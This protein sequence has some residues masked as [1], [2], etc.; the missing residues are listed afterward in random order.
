[1]KKQ[2][3]R[4]IFTF[5][6]LSMSAST[7]MGQKGVFFS[8]YAEGTSSNKYLEVYNGSGV[9]IN[10]NHYAIRSAS[11]GGG[12]S[13]S[14]TRFNG[15]D[16]ILKAGAVYVIGNA[17]A[18][19]TIK[20]SSDETNSV[21]F[22]NGNDARA[23]VYLSGS[24]TLI[25]DQVCD[26]NNSGYDDVAGI[27]EGFRNDGAWIRKAH[28]E[29]GNYG[30]WN[31]SRGT[32]SASSEWIYTPGPTA[33][34]TPSTLKLH[35]Q[36]P[37]RYFNS[38]DMAI[39]AYRASAS[40]IAD[41]FALLTFV[42]IKEG[43][44]IKI[45]D[46]K[47]TENGIAQCEGGLI[48]TAPAGIKSGDVIIVGNDNAVVDTGKIEGSSFG[49]SSGGD[50]IIIYEGPFF[51]PN[52]I[53]ALS[54]NAWSANGI[55]SCKGSNSMLPKGL[56]NGT[57]AIS[58]ENTQGGS[59]GNATNGFYSGS[60]TGTVAEVKA[61]VFDYT[62]WNGT[63]TKVDQIWPA[64]N[65]FKEVQA[66]S[67]FALINP[68]NGA[69]ITVLENDTTSV[70]I[71]WHSAKD[72]LGYAWKITT[73]TGDFNTPAIVLPSD[74]SGKDT[75]LTLT[76]GAV[77]AALA[78]LSI[79]KGVKVDLKW[80]VTAYFITGDSM[81]ADT[82]HTIAITRKD[83][84]PI[85][86]NFNAGDMAVIAYRMNASTPDEFALLTFVD[87]PAGAQLNFSD[88]KFAAGVQCDGGDL[89]WTAPAGGV[90][91]GTVIAVLNDNPAVSL[92]TVTGGSFGLSSGGD[93]IM[94]FE[95]PADKAKHIT[96]LSSNKWETSGIS[97]TSKSSSELPTGLTN[98]VNAISHEMTAGNDAGNTVNAFYT[99][100][101]EGTFDEIKKL[102]ADYTNWNGAA[103]GTEAQQW[104]SWNFTGKAASTSKYSNTAYSV[105]PNP[106][107]GMVFFSK[108]IKATVYTISGVEIFRMTEKMSRFD[109]SELGAGV[110]IIQSEFGNTHKVIL[111]K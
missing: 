102:V 39:V 63:S 52:F 18:N 59:S 87:I 8:E 22:F 70:V 97:C 105:Y 29:E 89:V 16:S 60:Q 99:G 56:T 41:E 109:L 20:D 55:T 71:S 21:T 27:S 94:I 90:K 72:A 107:S 79:P 25:L 37:I 15:P 106:T 33:T 108:P 81:N 77:D 103:A 54:S 35:E 26:P 66:S 6:L 67:G 44:Q 36:T 98:G 50:Q 104:P 7:L 3:L 95:G 85:T 82:F 11:N 48:W 5:G 80:T 58:H 19:Q 78:G 110:Y 53:T 73:A 100:T 74:N 42:D 61:R 24:D 30:D 68:A 57:N 65:F 101:M 75:T 32:D 31:R 47:Y 93:Q 88:D 91:A 111:T 84:T 17:S 51:N 69:D 10:L 45:T 4:T 13:S 64:W 83:D 62:N 23:L 46:M 2:I 14:L 40:T 49:L 12:W 43:T 28:I 76:S 92:G 9:D 96:A 38:G 1:M 86:Y 34:F